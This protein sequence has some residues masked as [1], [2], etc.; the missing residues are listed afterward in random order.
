MILNPEALLEPSGQIVRVAISDE[1]VSG[2][3]QLGFEFING[4]RHQVLL[5]YGHEWAIWRLRSK[6][7]NKTAAMQPVVEYL[8]DHTAR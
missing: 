5:A 6:L 8:E 7:E 4:A 3:I 2:Y 1:A